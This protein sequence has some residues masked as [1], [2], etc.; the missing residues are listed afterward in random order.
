MRAWDYTLDVP[1]R[2]GAVA[3]IGEVLGRAGINIEGIC[4]FEF[5][6]RSI[7]HVVVQ[8]PAARRLLER[9]SSVGFEV[10][11]ER[12]VILAPPIDDH[13]GVLGETARRIADEGINLDIIY[14]AS[15][16]RLVLGCDDIDAL[17]AAWHTVMAT[18][19]PG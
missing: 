2:P 6:G 9:F 15:G 1:S 4:G 16:G 3:T 17:E 7:L 19:A 10:R 18:P 8:D 11:E 13:P 14:L 5:Q 12:E